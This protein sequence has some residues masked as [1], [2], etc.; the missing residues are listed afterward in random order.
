MFYLLCDFDFFNFFLESNNFSLL[1][2]RSD[3]VFFAFPEFADPNFPL[4]LDRTSSTKKS[5]IGQLT[6]SDVKKMK[7]ETSDLSKQVK[8][9]PKKTMETLVRLLWRAAAPG[10]KP[11]RLPRAHT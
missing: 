5:E 3:K 9:P 8:A 11:L 6:M 1:F 10:L 2:W 7:W 4:V